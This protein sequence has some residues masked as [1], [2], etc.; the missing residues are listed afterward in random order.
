MEQI[1]VTGQNLKGV[2]GKCR[3]ERSGYEDSMQ[4]ETEL[5]PEM[6]RD[7]PV[8]MFPEDAGHE[9]VSVSCDK[10]VS[11]ERTW[12]ERNRD[13]HIPECLCLEAAAY[14]EQ[15]ATCH[16]SNTHSRSTC[17]GE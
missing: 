8:A 12:F 3:G 16:R 15:P 9:Q 4:L 14:S 6:K 10:S 17:E 11:T 2:D 5:R 1:K 7:R 13:K